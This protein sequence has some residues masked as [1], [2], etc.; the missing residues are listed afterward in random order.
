MGIVL[1]E[2]LI[3]EVGGLPSILYG[4]IAFVIFSVSALFVWSFRNVA[5]RHA[6]KA[7]TFAKEHGPATP[8]NEF[9]GEK[10]NH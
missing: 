5:N 3:N 6:P 4:V 10:A 2:G 7:A 8:I 9:G 1:A